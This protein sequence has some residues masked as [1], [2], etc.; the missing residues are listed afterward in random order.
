LAAENRIP[1]KA[2][3][4]PPAAVRSTEKGA[5]RVGHPLGYLALAD[6]ANDAVPEPIFGRHKKLVAQSYRITY[7]PPKAQVHTQ[8]KPKQEPDRPGVKL[9]RPP[10]H[11]DIVVSYG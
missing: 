8:H 4:K 10:G 5:R 11:C 1:K 2:A 3:E 7:M 9:S 6:V